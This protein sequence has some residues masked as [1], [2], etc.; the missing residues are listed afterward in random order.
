M[1]A[2]THPSP[3]SSASPAANREQGRLI[4]SVVT[5]V[6]RRHD[7]GHGAD[8][9]D[10]G[11]CGA[12]RCL[13]VPRRPVQQTPNRWRRS[14]PLDAE[15]MTALSGEQRRGT[16]SLP[17]L[18]PSAWQDAVVATPKSTASHTCTPH[19][20]ARPLPRTA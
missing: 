16:P 6:S 13:A 10:R 8:T 7:T 1:S 20:R 11:P 19:G 15:Q 3:Y 9:G 14:E 18:F 2:D 5:L 4:G 12:Q 17:S